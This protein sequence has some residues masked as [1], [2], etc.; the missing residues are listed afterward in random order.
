[1]A[2]EE[3]SMRCGR[4]AREARGAQLIGGMRAKANQTWP[5]DAAVQLAREPA[6]ADAALP[7][8]L[9]LR[10]RFWAETPAQLQIKF[11]LALTA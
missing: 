8:H 7:Q 10:A 3:W 6:N 5:R 4:E 2:P 1:M 9:P 11:K